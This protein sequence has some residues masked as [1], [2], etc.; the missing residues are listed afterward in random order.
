MKLDLQKLEIEGKSLYWLGKIIDPSLPTTIFIHGFPDNAYVWEKLVSTFPQNMNV[1]CPFMWATYDGVT[2]PSH[3]YRHSLFAFR[4]RELIKSLGL[5]KGPLYVVAHDMGGAVAGELNKKLDVKK[6]FFINT[7]TARQF[8]SH[9]RSL[10]QA[11]R[12]SYMIPMQFRLLQKILF[13]PGIVRHQLLKRIYQIGGAKD[14][15]DYL[16]KNEYGYMGGEV[17]RQIP[18]DFNLLAKEKAMP[19][20]YF[21]GNKDYFLLP[22]TKEELKNFST[23]ANIHHF[24]CGH[25]PQLTNQVELSKII[26]QEIQHE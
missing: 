6:N 15:S 13:S 25:W 5:E 7:F 3:H 1:I 20:I 19:I 9:T 14:V 17:Y 10:G 18:R 26:Q 11:I 2:V 12:S 22:P 23:M 16:K 21:W 24:N 8:L 4:I